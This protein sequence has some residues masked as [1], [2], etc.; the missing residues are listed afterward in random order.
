MADLFSAGAL[1]KAVEGALDAVPRDKRGALV[2]VAERRG[3]A[4]AAKFVIATRVGD[5]WTLEGA[6]SKTSTGPMEAGVRV[7]ATW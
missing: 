4:W 3:D 6:V 5:H 2:A 7:T 1:Q